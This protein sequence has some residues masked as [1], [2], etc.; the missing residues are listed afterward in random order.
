MPV[1]INGATNGSVTLAAPDTGSDV[2]LTLPAAAGTAATTAY[3]DSAG[4]L[5]L[6]TSQSFSAVSSVSINN[7]FSATYDNYQVVIDIPTKS[8]SAD[9]AFKLRASGANNAANNSG[10]TRIFTGAGNF[11]FGGGGD[12]GGV[13]LWG[14]G[15]LNADNATVILNVINPNLA[16]PTRGMG[17]SVSQKFGGGNY[18]FIQLMTGYDS[19]STAWDGFTIDMVSACSGTIRVYGYKNGA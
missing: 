16:A 6:I 1:K 2:T 7:C 14:L 9:I 11:N 12:A 19:A 5:Q 8:G 13:A 17:H 3:A 18:S 10:W 15:T 4:G